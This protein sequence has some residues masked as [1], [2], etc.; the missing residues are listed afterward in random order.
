MGVEGNNKKYALNC[1]TCCGNLSPEKVV[2]LG[3]ATYSTLINRRGTRC[4]GHCIALRWMDY[5]VTILSPYG[6]RQLD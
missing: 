5:W 1:S 2:T 6:A 3:L 4:I